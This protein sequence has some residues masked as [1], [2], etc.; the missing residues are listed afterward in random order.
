MVACSTVLA[1]VCPS[2]GLPGIDRIPSTKPFL[3]GRYSHFNA[4]L[5]WDPCLTLADAL[6][7]L[8]L[9]CVR[10]ILVLSL[11]CQDTDGQKQKIVRFRPM[12]AQKMPRR[13]STIRSPVMPAP[14]SLRIS[15]LPEDDP[16]HAHA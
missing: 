6:N 14:Q 3:R 9:Q 10:L 15:A 1:M 8:S 4:K 2:H 11:V 5:A 16:A 12:R 7:F 13:A